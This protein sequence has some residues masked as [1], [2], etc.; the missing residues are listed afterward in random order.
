M[1]GEAVLIRGAGDDIKSL[2]LLVLSCKDRKVNHAGVSQIQEDVAVAPRG[3]SLHHV[4]PAVSKSV[5]FGT[6]LL[7]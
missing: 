2:C 5:I 1:L 4:N 6:G 7:S 3:V